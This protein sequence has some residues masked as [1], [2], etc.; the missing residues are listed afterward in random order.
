[1]SPLLF[2]IGKQK[3]GLGYSDR[4]MHVSLCHKPSFVLISMALTHTMK[5][6]HISELPSSF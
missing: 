3:G 2:S 1:M 4:T 6:I 5:D